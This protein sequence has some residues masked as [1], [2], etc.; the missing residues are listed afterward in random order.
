LLY[1][2]RKYKEQTR[3]PL[4]LRDP[5]PQLNVFY[6][7]DYARFQ[8]YNVNR[9][10]LNYLMPGLVFKKYKRIYVNKFLKYKKSYIISKLRPG[11][12]VAV[13]VASKN[14]F[15]NILSIPLTLSH[16]LRPF[17]RF[18]VFF[19]HCIWMHRKT[20]IACIRIILLKVRFHIIVNLF[21][22][23]ILGVACTTPIYLQGHFRSSFRFVLRHKAR[24]MKL[25]KKKPQRR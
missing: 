16:Y 5:F 18:R 22:P 10:S 25:S 2:R 19:G 9:Y 7:W 17:L 15:Y 11:T 21:A 12:A 13:V 23:N 20:G 6:F 3:I 4:D 24:M 8:S 1:T 14:F